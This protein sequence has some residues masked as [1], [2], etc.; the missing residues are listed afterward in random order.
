MCGDK[1]SENKTR[2]VMPKFL[3][4]ARP[5]WIF[6]LFTMD[7]GVPYLPPSRFVVWSFCMR[8]LEK[9]W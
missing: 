4:T 6:S 3:D 1:I 7:T 9:D 8:P 2:Y 5:R